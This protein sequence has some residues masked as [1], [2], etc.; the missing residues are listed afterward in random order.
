M[1][2]QPTSVKQVPAGWYDDGSGRL[3]Y[4]DGALWTAHFAE[5]Q[6]PS[7]S[8]PRPVAVGLPGEPL[9]AMVRTGFVLGLVGFVLSWVPVLGMTLAFAGAVCATIGLRQVGPRA[10]AVL[11]AVFGAIGTVL[12]ILI[13]VSFGTMGSSNEATTE[14][15]NHDVTVPADESDADGRSDAPFNLDVGEMTCGQSELADP[16]AGAPSGAFCTVDVVATSTSEPVELVFA[17]DVSALADGTVVE[18]N[19][20]SRAGDTYFAATIPAGAAVELSLVFDV[21]VG[22]TPESITIAVDGEDVTAPLSE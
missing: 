20:A 15:A 21:P 7:T 5:Q 3:R 17:T 2:E 22:V 8:T 16:L 13:L 12:G 18:P 1:N 19:V 9:P 6:Q 11:G 10:L 4:W 14:S